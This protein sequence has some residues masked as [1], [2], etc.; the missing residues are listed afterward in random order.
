MEMVCFNDCAWMREFEC[1][2]LGLLRVVNLVFQGVLDG[3]LNIDLRDTNTT[4]MQP[5]SGCCGECL[6]CCVMGTVS[7]V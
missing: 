3:E 6:I 7:F 2:C 5:D 1:V 4:W